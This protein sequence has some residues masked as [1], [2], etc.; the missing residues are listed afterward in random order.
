MLLCAQR[1]KCRMGCLRVLLEQKIY[2]KSWMPYK[3]HI[4][5]SWQPE[6]DHLRN[7]SWPLWILFLDMVPKKGQ[8]GI[9]IVKDF[10]CVAMFYTLKAN[11]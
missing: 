3:N 9:K 8:S 5:N 11:F 2:L 10:V 6:Q 1:F 7:F 4:W